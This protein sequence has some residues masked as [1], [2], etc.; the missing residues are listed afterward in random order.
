MDAFARPALVVLA[1]I[2]SIAL[3]YFGAPFFIP[4]LLALL[5]SYAL[6]PVADALTRVLRWRVLSAVVV[7]SGLLGLIGTG[8]WAWSDDIA[9]VWDRVPEAAHRISASLRRTAQSPSPVTEVKKAAAEIE[10]IASTGKPAP[11]APP[12]PPPAP[13]PSFWQLVWEGGKTVGTVGAEFIGVVFLVFF[14]LA[15]LTIP[16]VALLF[17]VKK[18]WPVEGRRAQIRRMPWLSF[19]QLVYSA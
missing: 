15:C 4:L 6:S 14:M 11:A 3:L 12:T 5:I 8:L 16:P 7:V 17:A 18:N 13:G 1:V 19:G 2:A 10:A 9:A